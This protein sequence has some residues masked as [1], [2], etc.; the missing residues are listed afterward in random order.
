[1]SMG[2]GSCSNVSMSMDEGS[3]FSLDVVL[4]VL[5]TESP[6]ATGVFAWTWDRGWKRRELPLSATFVDR[7]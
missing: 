5:G 6:S 7:R 2:E 4:G 1:M 3:C